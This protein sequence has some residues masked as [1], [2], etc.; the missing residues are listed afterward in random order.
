MPALSTGPMLDRSTGEEPPLGVGLSTVLVKDK[1]LVVT[2]L[3]LPVL[4]HNTKSGGGVSDGT[5][6][7]V[8]EFK[9]FFITSSVSDNRGSGGRFG[10][11]SKGVDAL[12]AV[13]PDRA[14][15]G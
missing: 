6:A 2:G 10:P 12:I 8:T 4:R 11:S 14:T 9:A 13:V 3:R 7:E 5:I 1:E 15:S